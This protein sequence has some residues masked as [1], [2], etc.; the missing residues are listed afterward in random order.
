MLYCQRPHVNTERLKYTNGQAFEVVMPN[1][2][3][4]ITSQT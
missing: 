4:Q 2:Y 1:P 3:G